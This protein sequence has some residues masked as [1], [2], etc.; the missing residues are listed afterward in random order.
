MLLNGNIT[1]RVH[2]LSLSSSFVKFDVWI[3]PYYHN[4]N[5]PPCPKLKIKLKKHFTLYLACI[6]S[7][8][9]RVIARVSPSRPLLPLFLPSTNLVSCRKLARKSWLRRLFLKLL[10]SHNKEGTAR[11][12]W[13]I[14]IICWNIPSCHCGGTK[15]NGIFLKL[16]SLSPITYRTQKNQ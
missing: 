1:F 15:I 5:F 2:A 3:E 8:S 12:V 4:E 16:C 10:S 14:I 13:M 6:T 11:Y 7:V 9:N